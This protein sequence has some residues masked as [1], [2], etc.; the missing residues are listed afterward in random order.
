MTKL[1]K[2]FA[3]SVI[4]LTV[5]TMSG[6]V[7]NPAKAAA[8]AGDLIKKDGLST[9]YYLGDDGKRYVFPNQ[10]VYFSWYKDF[11]GVVTVSATELSSYPLGANIVMRP[12]TKLVKIVS[13]P[14]VYVVEPNG[15]LKKIQS[16]ADATALFGANWAKRVVDVADAFFTN[17]TIGTPLA[18]GTIPVGSLVKT[19][20]SSDIYYYDGTTYNKFASEAAFTANRF[21]FDNVITVASIGTTGSDIT[22][23]DDDL[24]RTSQS[25]STGGIVPGQGTGLTV[26]LA[27][28]TPAGVTLP[29]GAV[30]VPFTKFNVTASN[31]GPVTITTLVVKRTGVGAASEITKVY[32]YEGNTRLTNGRTINSTTHEATF[33]TFNYTVPAGTTKTLTIVADVDDSGEHALGLASASAITTGGA[34]V[35]GSFPITGNKM[36]LSTTLAGKADVEG[37]NTYTLK[38]GETNVEVGAFTVYVNN[39]EDAQVEAITLYN[40]ERDILDNLKLYRGTDLVATGSKSGDYITFSLNNAYAISKGQSASFTVKGDVVGAQDGDTAKLNIRYKTDVRIKGMTY[41]AYLG[42]DE[43]INAAADTLIN[44]LIAGDQY[45]TINAEA[46]Q[47]TL[48][49]NGPAANNIAR[50]SDNIVLTKFAITAQSTMDVEQVGVILKDSDNADDDDVANLEIVCDGS[51]VNEWADPTESAAG[52]IHTDTNIWT[53]PAGVTKQCEIRVD[54]ETAKTAGDDISADV[55]I[56]NWTFKDS[57]GDTVTDVV[58]SSDIVGNSM[59]VVVAALTVT[60]ASTPASQNWVKGSMID[61]NGYV[62]A[63]G[64]AEAVKVTSITLQGYYD[65]DLDGTYN[66]TSAGVD[67]SINMKDA[68]TSV[69]LYNGTTKIGATKTLATDGSVIFNSL[70]WNL[71]AGATTKLVIK[72]LSSNNAPYGG[73]NDRVKF[74]ITGMDVEYGSG[75]SL[76]EDI[77]AVDTAAEI[78]ILQTIEAAGTLTI[79]ADANNPA[80]DILIMGANDQ[81]M[82]KVKFTSTKEVFKIEKLEVLA[83]AGDLENFTGVT[84][85]YTNSSNATETKTA[86]F[87]GTGL[88]AFSGLDI[89]VPKDSSAT[90]TVK[91]NLNTAT[92]GAT[93][94]ALNAGLT[95]NAEGT[96]RAVGQSSSTV[97]SD[98]GN[99]V[100]GATFH[101]RKTKPTFTYIS[102]VVG[103]QSANQE[104]LRF[105]ITADAGEDVIVDDLDFTPYGTY[106]S[107]DTASKLYEVGNSTAIATTG[108]GTDYRFQAADFVNLTG[109]TVTKGTTKTFYVTTDTTGISTDETFSLGIGAAA[110]DI[111]WQDGVDTTIDGTYVQTLPISGASMKY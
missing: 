72:G 14:S 89:N 54:V 73:N 110:A 80:A 108:A 78:T 109:I 93:S 53:L 95:V 111:N 57:N 81:N 61:V 75:T 42:L 88:A 38:V 35:T 99:D 77:T 82:L 74:A 21:S 34:A 18:S 23:M 26:S 2:F 101:V 98:A 41:N 32:L 71:A 13:D 105:S 90:V 31:D 5:I 39:T 51:V 7:V 104:V 97:I 62:F 83:N 30:S 46:G 100:T 91:A 102:G 50:N 11:S 28:D 17:Y 4:V 63:V 70:S 33:S 48:T 106:T 56:S 49:F 87:D 36:S 84:L 92:G 76:A 103:G 60:L 10:D 55:D 22:G 27:S 47:V 8:Q 12:G 94:G 79:S 67:N 69:E 3:V 86:Y 40:S 43:T 16:E 107:A 25:G 66:D 58:P 15:V 6:V 1:R 44:E 64:D 29:G 85:T 37:N 52:S 65:E 59:N 19:S 24:V 9:V 96:F 68:L 45:Q 20:G